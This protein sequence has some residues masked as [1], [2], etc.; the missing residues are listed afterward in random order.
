MHSYQFPQ[1]FEHLD[2]LIMTPDGNTLYLRSGSE[3]V[4][5]KKGA[6][7]FSIREVVDLSLG[8]IKL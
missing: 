2:Q 7:D 8:K 6:L 5:A 4:V 3:L 1:P